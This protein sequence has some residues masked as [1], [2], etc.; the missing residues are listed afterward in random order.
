M[1]LGTE[2]KESKLAQGV[3]RPSSKLTWVNQHW[4]QSEDFP[5]PQRISPFHTHSMAS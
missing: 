1:L 5:K 4:V 2:C 3:V